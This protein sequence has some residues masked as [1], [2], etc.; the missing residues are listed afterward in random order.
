M[1]A[2]AAAIAGKRTFMATVVGG[3]TDVALS[4]SRLIGMEVVEP[5][6]SAFGHR[7]PVTIVGIVAVVDVAVKAARTMKPGAGADKYSA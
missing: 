7:S 2:A 3:V 6:C 5:L 4:V 1:S